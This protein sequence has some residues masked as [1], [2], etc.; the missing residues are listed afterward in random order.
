[1][2]VLGPSWGVLV[3]FHAL[4]RGWFLLAGKTLPHIFQ[5]YWAENTQR[6]QS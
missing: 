4:R 3:T 5:L 6:A 2:E 1:M